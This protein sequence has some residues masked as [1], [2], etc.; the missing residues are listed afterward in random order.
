[1]KNSLDVKQLLRQAAGALPW[2]VFMI[3]TP[4]EILIPTAIGWIPLLFWRERVR[5]S[6]YGFFLGTV[7]RFSVVLSLITI[8]TFL[9]TKAEDVRIGPFSRRDVSLGE[10]AAAGVIFR[11]VDQQ[12]DGIRV[13]L[14]STTPTR[15]EVMQAITQSTG[16]E[17]SIFF[18]CGNGFTVLFGNIGSRIRVNESHELPYRD[19]AADAVAELG[20]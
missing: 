18:P 3:L 13:M 4:F 2:S 8:A 16:F 1:M 10:L 7:A 6:Q 17:A 11:L 12:N 19:S 5:S 9:P 20:R 15:R 14:P